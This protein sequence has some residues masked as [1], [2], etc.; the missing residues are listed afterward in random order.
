LVRQLGAL[1]VILSQ[2]KTKQINKMLKTALLD[3][4]KP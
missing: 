1:D 3:P 4:L 2:E